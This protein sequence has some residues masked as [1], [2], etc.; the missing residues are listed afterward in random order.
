MYA[1][2]A[3]DLE[4]IEL[5]LLRVSFVVGREFDGHFE[6]LRDRISGVQN[7]RYAPWYALF[8]V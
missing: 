7:A 2:L 8:V 3:G 6:R 4:A 1:A 5:C